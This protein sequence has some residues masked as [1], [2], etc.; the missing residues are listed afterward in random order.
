MAVGFSI[1]QATINTRLGQAA[2]A[3]REAMLMAQRFQIRI[4]DL[5]EDEDARKNALVAMGFSPE[6]AAAV[7]LMGQYLDNVAGVYYGIVQQGGEGG[8]N[9]VLFNFD[10]GL[11]P[12]WGMG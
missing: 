1:N 6:D 7:V 12:A 9:A 4:T 10:K 2:V 3:L 11:S 5:G 8:S